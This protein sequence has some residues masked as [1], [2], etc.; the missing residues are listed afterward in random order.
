M[1]KNLLCFNGANLMCGGCN[2]FALFISFN[3]R[4]F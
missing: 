2:W 3:T 1:I 4:N